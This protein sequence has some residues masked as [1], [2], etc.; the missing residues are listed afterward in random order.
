MNDYVAAFGNRQAGRT[1]PYA[2]LGVCIHSPMLLLDEDAFVRLLRFP[3]FYIARH[4][5][6]A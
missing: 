5:S 3:E 4:E 6:R 2:I 1:A